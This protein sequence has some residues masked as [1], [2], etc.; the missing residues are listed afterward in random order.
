M[1]ARVGE[2]E[3]LLRRTLSPRKVSRKKAKKAS[4]SMHVEPDTVDG[5]L[6]RRRHARGGAVLVPETR[7]QS[8]TREPP[9]I[10]ATKSSATISSA[11]P[12]S[13]FFVDYTL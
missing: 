2:V 5:A 6:G 3:C 4:E 12:G 10:C 9:A 7:S 11:E 13:F 1:S 8:R